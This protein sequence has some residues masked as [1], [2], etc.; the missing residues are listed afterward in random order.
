M[1]HAFH[2]L[3]HAPLVSALTST[4]F[5][6]QHSTNNPATHHPHPRHGPSPLS[7][8]PF[9]SSPDTS[10]PS[11]PVTSKFHSFGLLGSSPVGM[12]SFLSPA[13]PVTPQARV[14]HQHPLAPAQSIHSMGGQPQQQN[15]YKTAIFEYLS[16]I[17]SDRLVLPALTL[18]YLAGRNP[19]NVPGRVYC[20]SSSSAQE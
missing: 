8:G 19:G 6:N 15:P 9:S 17:D 16:G 1:L 2:V 18:I 14:N 7:L 20:S 4:L 12:D 3:K 10:R 5:S 13:H 11:S